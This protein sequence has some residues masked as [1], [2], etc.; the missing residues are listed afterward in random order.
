MALVVPGNAK[1]PEYNHLPFDA[2]MGCVGSLGNCVTYELPAPVAKA[3]DLFNGPYRAEGIN[4]KEFLTMF[5]ETRQ[6][7]CRP[8]RPGFNARCGADTNAARW[9]FCNNAPSEPCAACSACTASTHAPGRL[10]A[11]TSGSRR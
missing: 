9:G 10:S 7:D 4:E 6:R 3:A 11:T 2:V 1:Y 5:N 8:Q